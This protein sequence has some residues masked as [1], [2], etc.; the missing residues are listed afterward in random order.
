MHYRLFGRS[1]LRVSELCLGTMTFGEESKWGTDKSESHKVFATFLEAGGNF[2]DT[3][4]YYMRGSSESMLGEFIAPFRDKVVVATKY[5]LTTDPTNPNAQGNHKKNM[6]QALHQSLKRLKTDYIDLYWIHAWD[7]S[8]PEEEVLRALDD[9]VRAGKILHIGISNAPAWVVAR[10]NAIAE[11]KSWT[12][13]TGIQSQYN[14]LE[15]SVERDLIPMAEALN[16]GVTA[17]SPLGMG[18]LTGKYLEN[19]ATNSRFGINPRWGNEFMTPRSRE[20]ASAVVKVAKD[21]SKSPAQIAL[22]WLMQK[23]GS[24]IP[25]VGA[26]NADQL[27]ENLG[28]IHF[29]LNFDF[30]RMLD[31]ISKIELGYPNDFLQKESIRKILSSDVL[32]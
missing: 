30:M 24:I 28:A 11:L 10:S 1:G 4:N 20:I 18:I 17:W 16:I 14:L 2:V 5:S 31:E 22:R 13:F 25:I 15:R 21:L 32:R 27:T 7:F 26:K 12:C 8:T 23:K 19:V 29:E 3:A 6:V 9:L